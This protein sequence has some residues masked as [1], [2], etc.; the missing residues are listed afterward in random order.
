M[1]LRMRAVVWIGSLGL[2]TA[3]LTAMQQ[4]A[5]TGSRHLAT[6]FE[7]VVFGGHPDDPELGVGGLVATLSRQGHEVILAYGTTYRGDRRVLGR[8]EAEVRQG[9]A[10]AAC[11]VLGASPRFFP[12]A[13]EKLVADEAT[14]RAIAAWL[15]E[16]K[17]DIVVT[18]WPLDTHPNH[19]VVSSLVWQCYRRKGGWSLYFFEV[20]T[21]QQTL[22]FQP[23]LSL[24]IGPV[25]DVNVKRRALE[26]H[27]SQEPETI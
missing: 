17:P 8:P 4:P 20:M 22:A 1:S 25:R 23:E 12:Y 9:E 16:V 7:I 6:R 19:H 11:K 21:D 2:L 24:D 18:H 14:R 5:L 10:A 26:Q 13:H 15:D 3:P 27:R